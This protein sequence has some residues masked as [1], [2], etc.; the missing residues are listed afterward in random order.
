MRFQ[1]P[2][3]RLVT[4]LIALFGAAPADAATESA[5]ALQPLLARR[6]LAQETTE[7]EIERFSTKRVPE[8]PSPKT[9]A[10]WDAT[11]SRLR[12]DVLEKVIFRGAQ[13]RQWRDAKTQ[14]VWQETIA[15]GPGYRIRK[16]RYEA[17]PGLWIPALLYEPENRQGKTAVHLAVNGHDGEGK[18]AAYKQARCINLAKRG[19]ISLNVEWLNMGQLRSPGS[20]HYA[21]NQLDLCGVSGLAPFY[22]GMSRGLDVLLALPNVDRE[23]VAVSGLSG[24]GWQ[25]IVISSLDTRVTL[26][27]PVAGYSGFRT[28]A[29]F[30]TD[31]GDSE[32]TPNDLATVADY[33]HLTALM[34]GRAA[35]LTNNAKD[36]CCFAS[37]HA[38]EP[39]V[40]AA[41]PLFKLRGQPERLQT[42]VNYDPGTHNFDQDNREALYRF[43]GAMFFPND[44]TWNAREIPSQAEVKTAAEL[45]VAMPA[46][47]LNL[48]E[49]ALAAMRG[50]PRDPEAAKRAPAAARAKLRE[51]AHFRGL[52][53]TATR[54]ATE[55]ASNQTV[56]FW[57]LAV[58]PEWSIPVTEFTRGT[59]PN[60]STV[61]LADKGR[62]SVAAEVE[63]LLAAGQRVLAVDLLGFGEAKTAKRDFLYALLIAAVGERQL[64]V[65]ADQLAAVARWAVKEF[66]TGPVAV[67]A[68]GPRVSF[69]AQVTAALERD[70]GSVQTSPDAMRSLTELIVKNVGADRQTEQFCFGLLET[71]D[72]PQL[73]ALAADWRTTT[74]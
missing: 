31:L 21:L 5:T 43:L 19:I 60:G 18:A 26:C 29:A 59:P 71:F 9:A 72:I 70:L 48:N 8:M 10:E 74:R 20:H 38:P 73:E 51:I 28:R 40:Q 37:D 41:A 23:R 4:V 64:G 56:T 42:H 25:T 6:V 67:V 36:N 47:N 44:K 66:K 17:L 69:I 13:A 30:P 52:S 15:G 55:R 58:G 62:E 14:V 24:G 54:Q 46:D 7:R 1:P 65:Q 27:N 45:A 68:N 3:L 63:R 34:A 50:L 32:Q 53:P 57:Q 35:L 16:L 2:A 22:L 49:L 61:V 39:L 11:A 12:R 33:T